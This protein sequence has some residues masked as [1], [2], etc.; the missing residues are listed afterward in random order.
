LLLRLWN[1]RCVL[2]ITTCWTK[3]EGYCS[4]VVAA[5]M[6]TRQK[7]PVLAGFA[8]AAEGNNAS[9]AVQG[10]SSSRTTAAAA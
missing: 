4:V 1:E 8:S 3:A 9:A 6:Y 10:L 5:C 7:C 2:L